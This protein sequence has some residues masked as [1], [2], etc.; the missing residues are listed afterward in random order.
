MK[1]S[2]FDCIDIQYSSL[3]CH[4]PDSLGGYIAQWLDTKYHHLSPITAYCID[5]VIPRHVQGLGGEFIVLSNHSEL[6][7][8]DKSLKSASTSVKLGISSDDIVRSGPA[9]LAVTLSMI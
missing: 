9:L 3:A 7:A 6:E 4:T 2:V 1:K 8:R 5:V